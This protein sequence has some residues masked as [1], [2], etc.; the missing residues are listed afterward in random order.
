MKVNGWTAVNAYPMVREQRRA[1]RWA[2][3]AV[4]LAL[5]ACSSSSKA[6]P[7]AECVEYQSALEKCTQRPQGLAEQQ[8]LIVEDGR[9]SRTIS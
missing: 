7:I 8:A 5:Y 9:G 4:A 3:F 1:R 2:V 6:G